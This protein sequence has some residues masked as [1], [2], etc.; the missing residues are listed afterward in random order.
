MP[1]S[2][3]ALAVDTTPVQEP[4]LEPPREHRPASK[5][6]RLRETFENDL[7]LATWTSPRP[8]LPVSKPGAGNVLT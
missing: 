3:A 4:C 6:G 8:S 2:F 1:E 7:V 5:Q